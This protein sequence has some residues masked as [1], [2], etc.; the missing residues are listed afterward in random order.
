MSTIS[1]QLNW[2]ASYL[3]NDLYKR[4]LRKSKAGETEEEVQK[5]YVTKARL[6]TFLIVL[7]GLFATS[8]MTS[9]DSAA[10]FLIECGA[11]LGL[12]LIL[13]WYWWR[14]NAWSE[15]TA[16]LTPF[17]GYSLANYVFEFAYPY[18]FLFTV[19]LSTVAW[20][21]VTFITAPT[22]EAT[23]QHFYKKVRPDGWW[24]P[25]EDSSVKK[26]QIGALAICWLSSVAMVYACLFFIG[27][28]IFANYQKAI[29][30]LA[31]MLLAY[32]ILRIQ[33]KKTRIF[34]I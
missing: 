30:E 21:V 23:L 17:I 19:L 33:L 31:F 32:F 9:I 8:Q 4:F 34:D 24:K 10:T 22:K 11:G 2:G 15:I 26:N 29:I 3:T 13:R 18:N 12:V 27:D 1:T 7:V 16:S 5:D 25:Y 28:L 6:F 14:I 20:L